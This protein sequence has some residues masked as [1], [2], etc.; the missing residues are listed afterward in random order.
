MFCRTTSNILSSLAS[1]R[2]VTDTNPNVHFIITLP[3]ELVLHLG[4]VPLMP[5]GCYCFTRGGRFFEQEP[6]GG[7]TVPCVRALTIC[8]ADCSSPVHVRL[9]ISYSLS[10]PLLTSNAQTGLMQCLI[11]MLPN[12]QNLHLQ[13]SE[14]HGMCCAN[15]FSL[16]LRSE[17]IRRSSLC[18]VHH[19]TTAYTRPTSNEEDWSVE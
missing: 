18:R 4:F 9:T 6:E 14:D 19:G 16:L 1:F 11:P 7:I 8:L 3:K 15:S 17:A 2:S 13:F 5:F 10:W 12:L